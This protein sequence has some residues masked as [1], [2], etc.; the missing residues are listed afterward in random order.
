MEEQQPSI[1]R[2]WL[3]AGCA[4]AAILLY[5]LSLSAMSG[6]GQSDTLGNSLQ[7]A[8]VSLVMF[9]LWC[10]LGAFVG[11]GGRTGRQS[12]GVALGGL[13]LCAAGMIMSIAAVSI[14]DDASL[15]RITP[16]AMPPLALLFG[17]WARF[18]AGWPRRARRLSGFAFVAAA[19]AAIAAVPIA[20]QRWEAAAPE[21]EAAARRAEAEMRR[22]EAEA[23][24]ARERQF[25]ALGPASRLDDFL[26]FV[27]AGDER[28]RAQ[29]LAILAT[30]RTRQADAVRLIDAD[31]LIELDALWE[32]DLE[33]TPELCRSYGGA[34][35]RF[36]DS[37]PPSDPSY[38]SI[39]LDL[40]QQIRNIEWLMTEG[41]DLSAPVT[42]LAAMARAP[43]MQSRNF[44]ARLEA[45]LTRGAERPAR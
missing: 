11:L 34:L 23:A 44:A 35:T 13:L 26:Y 37:Y 31:R 16:I 33:V 40:S 7:S 30:S 36:L 28:R 38:S 32:F 39:V 20:Q 27:H 10:A 45:L 15:A 6:L 41:C 12:G 24:E 25:K 43:N 14:A 21:R 22:Q 5:L 2:T 9:L 42:R 19:A 1:G 18:S 3:E 17:I 8:F 4:V 29:A